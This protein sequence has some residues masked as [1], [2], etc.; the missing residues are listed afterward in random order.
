MAG[1]EMTD[2]YQKW[3]DQHPEAEFAGEYQRRRT[4]RE[5]PP[6]FAYETDFTLAAKPL[7][8]ETQVME[9]IRKRMEDDGPE[10]E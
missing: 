4:D 3:T 2:K 6:D 1:A 5:F 8:N 10:A 7:H 9:A